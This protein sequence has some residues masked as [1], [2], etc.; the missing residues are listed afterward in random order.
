MKNIEVKACTFGDRVRE[1]RLRNWSTSDLEKQD[2]W[3]NT[4]QGG[5]YWKGRR[6][7]LD[8]PF[9][10][11]DLRCRLASRKRSAAISAAR[12]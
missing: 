2:L 6:S 11:L 9:G 10:A 1:S 8:Q 7:P 5:I 3:G 4:N 12:L